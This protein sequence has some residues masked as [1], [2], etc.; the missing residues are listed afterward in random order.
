MRRTVHNLPAWVVSKGGQGG[1]TSYVAAKTV[2]ANSSGIGKPPGKEVF[3]NMFDSLVG[4]IS[5]IYS[6]IYHF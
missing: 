5:A 6:G 1:K 2:E 4:L 3:A